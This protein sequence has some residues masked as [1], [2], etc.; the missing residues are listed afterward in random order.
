MR[1]TARRKFGTTSFQP[2]TLLAVWGLFAAVTPDMSAQPVGKDWIGRRVVQKYAS[3]ALK[4]D[5]QFVSPNA[6]FI[7]RV[8]QVDGPLLRLQAPQHDGWALVDHV[9]PIDQAIGF[10]TDAIRFNP[11]DSFAYTMRAVVRNVETKEYNKALA[12]F[13]EAIRLEPDDGPAYTCRGNVRLSMNEPERAIADY[14]EAIKLDPN[15]ASILNN[16]GDTYRFLRRYDK[17]IADLDLAI[18]L[19]PGYANAYINRG[20]TWSDQKKYEKANADY[21]VAIKLGN[22]VA[23]TYRADAWVEK[24]EYDK[25]IAD[26]T[27]AIR[28]DSKVARAYISRGRAWQDKNK[29]VNAAADFI[30]AVRVDPKDADGHANLAWLRS[31]CPNEKFRDGKQAVQSATNACE[32]TQWRD[33][34]MLDILATAHAE[35]GAFDLAVKWESRAIEL[36]KYE[37]TKKDYRSR[38]RLFQQKKPYRAELA[39]EALALASSIAGS[40][41]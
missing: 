14:S 9:V 33:P 36:E 34:N 40:R 18:R 31:T 17:A 15:D 5:N 25:A 26:C 13:D 41:A 37:Q 8:E 11:G 2:A 29:I 38:L 27:E 24:R 23:Y 16:R 19:D 6:L 7:F 4:I 22:V 10:F 21:N 3:F 20:V 35:T 39:R 30:D 1:G 32:L 28:L 12:D